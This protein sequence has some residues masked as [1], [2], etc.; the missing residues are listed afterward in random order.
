MGKEQYDMKYLKI[1]V[2]LVVMAGLM[3]VAAATALAAEPV[4][5]WEQCKSV[6]KGQ[7]ENSLCSKGKTNGGWETKE[8]SE[9]EE[10]TSSSAK[11]EF[12]DTKAPGGTSTIRCTET[13]AGWIVDLKTEP[14]E[15]GFST[16]SLKNCERVAGGCEAGKAV[17]AEPEDLPSGFAWELRTR[18]GMS[19]IVWRNFAGTKGFGVKIKCTVAGVGVTD[20]CFEKE[21]GVA[22]N[23]PNGTVEI[24]SEKVSFEEDPGECSLGGKESGEIGGILIIKQRSG[25]ATYV[26]ARE[27]LEF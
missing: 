23:G 8:I 6:E 27:T 11:L 19:I 10:V 16:V 18:A 2:V 13:N 15:S 20:E 12:T 3:A 22:R 21:L 1:A 9:T 24:E 17:T 14:G 5:R 4:P 26:H 7:W 25:R